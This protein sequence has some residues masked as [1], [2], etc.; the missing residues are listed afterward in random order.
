MTPIIYLNAQGLFL[1]LAYQYLWGLI[2]QLQEL[3][4][5]FYTKFNKRLLNTADNDTISSLANKRIQPLKHDLLN[6][7][8]KEVLTKMSI[9]SGLGILSLLFFNL[10]DT[11][12]VSLLGTNQLA[13]L[14]FTFPVTFIFMSILIGLGTGLSSSLA[15]LI[16]KGGKDNIA[17]YT[18][19]GLL[20][21]FLLTLVLSSIGH[22]TITPLFNLLGAESVLI[23][24]IKQYLSVWYIAVLFLVVPLMGNSALRAT[25]NTKFPSLVMAVA[26]LINVILDPLFIFGW[27]VVPAMGIQGAA[28]ATMISWALS[29]AASVILLRRSQLVAKFPFS[30]A[31]TRSVWR[32]ILRIGR[33]AALSQVVNPIGNAI[34]M[35]MLAAYES[36]AVAAFGVGIRIE[37]LM[38]IAVTALSSSLTPFIA[39]NLGAGHT[40]RARNALLG[41]AKFSIVCQFVCYIIVAML[42]KPIATLF[43]DDPYVIQYIVVFL[44]IVPFAYGALG[45]VIIFANGLNAYNRPGS[46]LLLNLARLF[47]ILL[48][49]AWL[50]SE[51]LGPTGIFA[52][53]AIANILIGGASYLL[54]TQIS[55][56]KEV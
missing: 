52:A 27:G 46:S 2:I 25:G 50:G 49:M 22:L 21:G 24:Y 13:A 51:L 29:M 12:F 8:P 1:L 3:L 39:Q 14:S 38:L 41:S 18:I 35:S 11:Y 48:P 16:G 23:P 37:S 34:L 47:L 36:A 26:G 4:N 33:P 17:A 5:I 6:S 42:A 43:S 55:E 40:T 56:G 30:W 45:I 53:I 32:K 28:V 10:A 19:N 9:P 54:A 31:Y 44:R 7:S 15:R 20:L